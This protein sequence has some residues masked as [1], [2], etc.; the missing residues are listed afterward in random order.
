VCYFATLLVT[1]G[2]KRPMA[3]QHGCSDWPRPR[4]RFRGRMAGWVRSEGSLILRC[5]KQRLG[6]RQGASR[7]SISAHKEAFVHG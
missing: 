7:G 4:R 6:R 5:K 3:L 2:W 1:L